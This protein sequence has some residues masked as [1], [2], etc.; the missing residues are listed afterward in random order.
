MTFLS[1]FAHFRS[2]PSLR[3]LLVAGLLCLQG[4]GSHAQVSPPRPGAPGALPAAPAPGVPMDTLTAAATNVG[5]KRCLPAISRLSSLTVNGSTGNDVLVDWDRKNPD[6]GPFFSLSG[7]EYKNASLAFSLTA[8]PDATGGCSVAAERI[9]VAPFACRSIAQ[10][11][12]GGYR[13]TQLLATFT[14]YTDA[15]DPGATVTLIDSP[16]GC[17]IIRRH[18]EYDWKDPALKAKSR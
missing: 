17:L 7:V 5:V 11:E 13:A 8:V 3:T 9:S 16:P 14:V 12:L 2:V 10:Q 6:G 4:V 1:S 18:V 15:R